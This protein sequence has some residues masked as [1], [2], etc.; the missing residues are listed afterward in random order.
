V[1]VRLARAGR[2]VNGTGADPDIIAA[3][4]K[5]YLNALNKLYMTGE[6]LNP[7]TSAAV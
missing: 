7:Q 1:T 4:A 2:I 6:R 3:S 5:A